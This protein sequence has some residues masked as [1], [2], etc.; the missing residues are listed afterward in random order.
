[1][2]VVDDNLMNLKVVEGLLRPYEIK[3][4]MASSGE[5]C[6]S[7]LEKLRCDMIF[8]DHMMP[9]MDGV[10]TAHRIRKNVGSY[11]RDV[12]IIALTANAIDG[13]R[14][15]FLDE[16]FHG[17][18]TKPIEMSQM[19]KVLRKYIPADKLI[20]EEPSE[21]PAAERPV[22]RQIKKK[23]HIDRDKGVRYLGG[24]ADDY[25]EILQVYLSDGR[26]DIQK[27]QEKYQSE[28]WKNYTVYVHALKSTSFGIGADGLGEMAKAMETAGREEDLAYIH[29]NHKKMMG[30][31][32]EVLS[33]IE[34]GNGEG[35][36][37]S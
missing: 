29:A 37:R 8:M 36:E 7:K 18:I 20:W 28:D 6:L 15:M 35:R 2:L 33:E 10:E 24:N 27:I 13:A 11:F 1:M 34:R 5:E 22:E 23:T 32:E 25:E 19:E 30:M 16:G 3:V 26:E 31:Y 17:Y 21:Q 4:V 14:E 12:P 9:E